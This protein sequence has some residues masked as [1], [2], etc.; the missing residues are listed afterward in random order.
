MI[1]SENLANTSDFVRTS[2]H[3]FSISMVLIASAKVW[4]AHIYNV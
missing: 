4:L 3:D 1:F 2:P